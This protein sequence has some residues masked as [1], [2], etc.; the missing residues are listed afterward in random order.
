MKARDQ[1][2]GYR[3]RQP[4]RPRRELPAQISRS[5]IIGE[6]LMLVDT[7]GEAA[8][9]MRKLGRRLGIE[10]MSLYNY[11][12]SKDELLNAIADRVAAELELPSIPAE[13]WQQRIRSAVAAWARMRHSHPGGFPLLYRDRSATSQERAVTGEIMDAL[14]VAGLDAAG[15]A[16]T[17]QTLIAFLDGALLNWPPG[18]WN[19]SVNTQQ[20]PNRTD[21]E[22]RPATGVHRVPIAPF[23]W[24]DVFDTGLELFLR[25]IEASRPEKAG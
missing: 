3:S 1:A 24:T 25:G 20:L 14:A 8:L 13:N 10:A 6:A 4:G 21:L 2:E 19:A 18:I 22:A 16:P 5:R 11:V 9:T 17:Y 23:T 15:V 7:E 12:S